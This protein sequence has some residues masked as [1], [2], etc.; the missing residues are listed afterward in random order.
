MAKKES[1]PLLLNTD[2]DT[3]NPD[4]PNHIRI[5][6]FP[7]RCPICNDGVMP[8]RG[9]CLQGHRVKGVLGYTDI[10]DPQT[11]LSDYDKSDDQ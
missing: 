3:Y 4:N 11:K 9:A 1:K 7:S 6:M 10:S 2:L 8:S 5:E